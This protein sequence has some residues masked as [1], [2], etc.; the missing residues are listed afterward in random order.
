[1]GID[2][3]LYR[4]RIGLYSSC[5]KA[6]FQGMPINMAFLKYFGKLMLVIAG[7]EPN[8]C[9]T[10]L[11]DSPPAKRRYHAYKSGLPVIHMLKSFINYYYYLRQ[12]YVY[13]CIYTSLI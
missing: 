7:V 3:Q 1:M 6:L 8:P 10:S 2:L 4:L 13:K 5:W 9:P 12:L 11:K